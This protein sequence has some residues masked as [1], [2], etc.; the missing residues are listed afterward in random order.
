MFYSYKC[1]SNLCC[2]DYIFAWK[3]AFLQDSCQLFYGPGWL[4]LC[5]C[6]LKMH[7]VGEGPG[8][9]LWVL[10][11][12]LSLISSLLQYSCLENPMGGGAW[13]AVVHRVAEGLTR[14][15]DFDWGTSLSL[16]TF[17]HCRRERQPT[18]VFMPGESQGWGS[19]VGCRLWRCTELDMTEAT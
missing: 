12:F 7:V 15:S 3:P 4:T 13:K 9:N 16:F 2:W 18:P 14:L 11:H 8:A 1:S 6:Y 5:Q 19:L 17:M 10:R